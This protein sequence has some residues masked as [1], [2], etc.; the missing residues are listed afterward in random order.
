MRSEKHCTSPSLLRT[1]HQ[2]QSVRQ[3]GKSTTSIESPKVKN[4]DPMLHLIQHYLAL[5][6]A[7]SRGIDHIGS[8]DLLDSCVW[9][10]AVCRCTISGAQADSEARIPGI[11]MTARVDIFTK[12]VTSNPQSVTSNPQSA[13]PKCPNQICDSHPD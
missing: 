1:T 5:L 6:H 13:Q 12:A 11:T 8:S 4:P 3:P 7:S 9:V 10:H 2:S